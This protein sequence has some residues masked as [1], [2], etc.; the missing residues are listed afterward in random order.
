MW[1]SSSAGTEAWADNPVPQHAAHQPPHRGR[2]A[3]VARRHAG[4]GASGESRVAAAAHRRHGQQ[5]QGR[6]RLFRR[7]A[8][9]A[10]DIRTHPDV[11]QAAEEY[12][13]GNVRPCW[14][15]AAQGGPG[16]R[17]DVLV[18]EDLKHVKT[19][20]RG[21]FSRRFNRCLSHW[22]YKASESRIAQYCEEYGIVV[23]RKN[24]WKTSQCCNACLKWD[25]RSRREDVFRCVSCGHADHADFNAAKNL[26][27]LETVGV[28]GLGFLKSNG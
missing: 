7:P 11:R 15:G 28:Y 10:G 23:R 13:Q 25:R 3:P 6:L 5:L 26:R 1:A 4:E 18:L 9:R 8:R 24:P 12:V 19:D 17:I 22:L 14:P 21:T 27:F 2:L 20:R 16:N